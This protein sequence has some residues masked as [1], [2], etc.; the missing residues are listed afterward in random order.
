MLNWFIDFYFNPIDWHVKIQP[1]RWQ[2]GQFA[3]QSLP[4]RQ[5]STKI[6]KRVVQIAQNLISSNFY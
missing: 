1:I 6:D 3:P 2:G 4:N 5:F